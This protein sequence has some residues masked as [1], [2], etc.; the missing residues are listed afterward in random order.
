ME[1]TPRRMSRRTALQSLG[2]ATAAT[3]LGATAAGTPFGAP[4]AAANGPDSD[5]GP[6]VRLL[7]NGK[8]GRPGTYAFPSE[9]ETVTL[10]NGLARF[11]FNRNDGLSGGVPITPDHSLTGSSVIVD[12]TELAHNLTGQTFY[13][14][15]SGGKSGLMCTKVVVHRMTADLVEVAI[16]DDTNTVL[17]HEHHL[18]MRRGRRGL[19]GYDIMTAPAATQ[20][21]EVRMNTR[22]DRSIFSYA[23]NWER[24][25]GQQPTYAYLNTQEKVQDETWRIDGINNPDLPAPD[26]NS[27]NLPAGSVYSKYEWSLYHHENPMFGHH[28]HGFGVWF[29][30]LGGVTADT[31][32]AYYGVGP[33]HQDLAIHQD[34]IILNYFGANHYGLPA[35]DIPQGYRRL[36]GPWYTFITTGDE[37]DPDAMIADA[38]ATA[39]AE[40]A[41]NRHGSN[42]IADQ[43]YPHD[44]TTVTGRVRLADGRSAA[45]LWV[46]LSTEDTD[47]V[48]TIHE[49]TYFVRTDDSGRFVLPGIPPAW[50]PG[51]T[52]PGS[53]TLYVFSAGGPALGQYK[54]TGITVSGDKQDLG[55]I[56]WSPERRGTFLWQ[57]GLADR[58]GG[59]YAR[60]TDPATHAHPREYEKPATIPGEL[61]F[62]IGSSWEPEDWYYAQT[63][64]GTWTIAFDLDRVP[65]G[66]CYL[67]V[68]TSMQQSSPPTVA[69][70]GTAVNGALPDNNDSTIA[71]QADRSGQP[72]TAVLS[73]PGSALQ[74]GSNKITLTRGAGTA[75]GNG[76][77]WDTLLLEAD[78]AAAGAPARL[79]AAILGVTE[80]DGQRIWRIKITNTGRGAAYDVRL[81]GLTDRNG[82]APVVGGRDPNRFPVPV[83]ARLEAGSTVLAT[84]RTDR[85]TDRIRAEIS[86]DGGFT[87]TTT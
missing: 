31:L 77:G 34:A 45:D 65:D 47:A 82:R 28:G 30:P 87:R 23:Y 49:P 67:T 43:L 38:A 12:G 55:T 79:R 60:A 5:H 70:N 74:V 71:R 10:D 8:P 44:R 85:S 37:N 9:V 14:D 21:N 6:A 29:T 42:W 59:E 19:Y 80:R 50:R 25:S 64:A 17:Q 68:A 75:A 46:L 78:E 18:I 53:Y 40:I 2:V 86:A 51:S 61:T 76:L 57:I 26:S 52:D 3:G 72:R 48:S 33:T 73:F 24:G 27:G 4:R 1:I 15:S 69:V 81:A 36:Y 63:N 56:V 62:T 58:T 83:T 11:T 35:Y 66:T 20:I 7:L 54:R 41:E 22:W 32:C 39:R 13:V 84:A 16:V